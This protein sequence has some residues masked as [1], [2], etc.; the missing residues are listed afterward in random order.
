MDNASNNTLACEELVRN[1]KT[2]LLCEGEHLHVR[3]CAHILNIIVQDGMKII[4]GA[5]NKVRE[6]LKHIDSSPSRLQTFNSLANANGLPQKQ[7]IYLDIPNRWNATFKMLRE[8]LE[9]KSVLNSYANQ[10]LEVSPSEPEWEKAEAICEFLKAFEELTLTVSAHRRP[11]SHKFLTVVLCIRHALSDPGWQGGNSVLKDL[12]SVMQVKLDKYWDPY[13]DFSDPREKRDEIEF[14]L[15]LVIATVLDPRRKDVYLEFFYEKV[16]NN[17]NHIS[18]LIDCALRC[19][20]KYFDEYQQDFRTSVAYLSHQSSDYN[21]RVSSPIVG[22]RKLEEEFAQHKSRRR[23]TRTQKS[24]L[25]VYLE[26]E[27]EPDCEDFDI[28]AW[29][30]RHTDKFPILSAMA[31]DFLAIPLSTVASE[32]AFSCGGRILGDTRSFLTPKMLE[33]LVC[34]KD[35]LYKAKQINDEDKMLKLKKFHL[36]HF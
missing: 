25:D 23:Y 22:K 4:H 28:L 9:Y 27:P 14:N 17:F 15:A 36:F 33:A 21:I 3:C 35:W 12:A 30:K 7:G 26:E 6:L 19:M 10:N 8:A 24:E 31:R 5:I 1:N 29:W 20:R 16:V 2:Q 11:T 13:E 18:A 34:T 32:S